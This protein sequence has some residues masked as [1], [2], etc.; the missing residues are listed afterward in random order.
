MNEGNDGKTA[1]LMSISE[2]S[3]A[4]KIVN[5]DHCKWILLDQ[6]WMII[7]AI[8]SNWL[9][10]LTPFSFSAYLAHNSQRISTSILL[11]HQIYTFQKI[12]KLK[13]CTPC[14]NQ[15][16]YYDNSRLKISILNTQDQKNISI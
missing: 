10:V 14:F 4:D 1:V 3:N 5:R 11:S 16:A 9:L 8:S 6:T 7:K 13:M 2:K 12:Y 15:S